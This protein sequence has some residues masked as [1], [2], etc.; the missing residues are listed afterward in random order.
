MRLRHRG[1]RAA[2]TMA[3]THGR[4]VVI[5]TLLSSSLAAQIDPHDALSRLVGHSKAELIQRFGAPSD[6]ITTIDGERLIYETLDAGR[7]NGRSG[8]NTRAG[9]PGDFG[10]FP[11]TYSFRCRTEVVIAD[12]L[13]RAFNRSGNDCR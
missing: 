4:P 10:L 3:A 11:R 6:A 2:M 9:G 12:N 1:L 13:V 5:I 8:Q 7:V